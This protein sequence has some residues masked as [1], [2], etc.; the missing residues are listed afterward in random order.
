MTKDFSSQQLKVV[1]TAGAPEFHATDQ[2]QAHNEDL[3]WSL[4]HPMLSLSLLT[5]PAT[6]TVA[7]SADYDDDHMTEMKGILGEKGMWAAEFFQWS[8][9]LEL[10]QNPTREATMFPIRLMDLDNMPLEGHAGLE[11]LLAKLGGRT[12]VTV[13]DL[14]AIAKEW[15]AR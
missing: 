8:E 12:V 13:G 5:N 10:E 9:K 3:I 1:Y 14:Q 2:S 15:K 7:R 4:Y 11:F 6:K